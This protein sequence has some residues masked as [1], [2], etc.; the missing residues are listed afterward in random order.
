MSKEVTASWLNS[1]TEKSRRQLAGSIANFIGFGDTCIETKKRL[2]HG[3]FSRWVSNDVGTSMSTAQRAMRLASFDDR[4]VL[5]ES[6]SVNECLKILRQSETTNASSVTHLHQESPS[7]R[8][9]SDKPAKNSP[10]P[11]LPEIEKFGSKKLNDAVANG[12]VNPKDAAKI[13]CQPRKEQNKALKAVKE[14]EADT[15]T[16][17]VSESPTSVEFGRDEAKKMALDQYHCL[18]RM[19]DTLNG[20]SR[21]DDRMK[22]ISGHM[23][24][25]FGQLNDWK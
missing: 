10:S 9:I 4:N 16:E 5:L 12:D 21:N 15:L 3:E 11:A 13:I 22:V 18:Y 7:A 2:D 24:G 20:E 23:T 6:G 1:Q 25:I 8:D 19:I 14:G 17:A